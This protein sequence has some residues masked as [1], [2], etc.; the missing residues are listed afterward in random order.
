MGKLFRNSIK[1]I[2]IREIGIYFIVSNSI[3]KYLYHKIYYLYNLSKRMNN[4]SKKTY[5]FIVDYSN[6]ISTINPLVPLC[7][8]KINFRFFFFFSSFFSP[9]HRENKF[10]TSRFITNLRVI[11]LFRRSSD[12]LHINCPTRMVVHKFHCR[13]KRLRY[14]RL[15]YVVD[16]SASHD[17]VKFSCSWHYRHVSWLFLYFAS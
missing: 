3:Q 4:R 17:F 6:E 2:Y 16:K 15:I 11:A 5:S 14:R 7:F 13:V 9:R 10:I 8:H 1:Y 12:R